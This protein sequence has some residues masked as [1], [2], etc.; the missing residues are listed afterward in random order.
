M[1]E[2]L[3]ALLNSLDAPSLRELHLGQAIGKADELF[4]QRLVGG[5]GERLRL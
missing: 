2:L 1:F 4:L 5:C 3:H